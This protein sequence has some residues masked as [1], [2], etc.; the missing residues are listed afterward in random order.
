METVNLGFAG[1]ARGEIVLAQQIAALDAN[2]ITVAYGTNCWA[3]LP[4]SAD[5]GARTPRH[6]C[7]L[8]EPHIQT[9]RCSLLA[10]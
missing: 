2:V 9:S 4:R 7:K 3:T 6:F 10:R 1:S 5:M 8:S